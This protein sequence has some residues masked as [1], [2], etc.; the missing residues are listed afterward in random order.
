MVVL[1]ERLVCERDR[2][3]REWTA[4]DEV[5]VASEDG[6]D[7]ERDTGGDPGSWSAARYVVVP[8]ACCW[9]VFDR[10]TVSLRQRDTN[11]ALL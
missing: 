8:L 10:R 4:V 11:W 7:V 5:K 3:P 1:E 9:R 2:L 6:L